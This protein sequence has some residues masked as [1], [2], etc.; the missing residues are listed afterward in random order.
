MQMPIKGIPM[1]L[2]AQAVVGW[3]ELL[4]WIFEIT[5]NCTRSVLI[6]IAIWDIY[7]HDVPASGI[8]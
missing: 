1:T 4:N 7:V 8:L 6:C 5:N 3:S 2:A